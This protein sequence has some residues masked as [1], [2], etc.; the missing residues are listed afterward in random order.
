MPLLK[1]LFLGTGG[2][3]PRADRRMPGIYL[4]DW[5]GHRVLLDAGEGVQYALMANGI[6]PASLSYVAI[7]HGHEDHVLGLPGLLST[8]KM[9]GKSLKVLAPPRLASALSRGGVEAAT[10][11]SD[12]H[13]SIRCVEVCHTVEAC[14]WLFEWDVGFK[15]DLSKVEGFPKQALTKLIRGEAVEVGGRVVRPEDVAEPGHR[16]W[17]RLFYTGDTGPCPKALEAVG[18]T[19]VLIHEATFADDVEPAKAHEE[20][21]STVLDAIEAAKALGARLLILTHISARYDDL[22]RHRALAAS[23]RHAVV[24]EDGDW[25]LVRF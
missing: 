19:D 4:E 1:L 16:R 8:A 17:R 9:A 23:Y 22:G 6:S 13:M 10:S 12:R 5:E 2:A 14:G 11:A 25:V 18:W 7:T 15:L 20:G 3:V 24:P 21:H